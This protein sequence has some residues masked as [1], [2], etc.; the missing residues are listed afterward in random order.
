MTTV[1][2][3]ELEQKISEFCHF[4]KDYAARKEGNFKVVCKR[5]N[6]LLVC[7]NGE[8]NLEFNLEDL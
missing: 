8:V 5:D 4:L 6:A 1:P 7:I 2:E 3:F